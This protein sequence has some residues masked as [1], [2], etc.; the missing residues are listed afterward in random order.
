MKEKKVGLVTFRENDKILE[1]KNRPSDDV[2]NG[3][4][5]ILDE[6][7]EEEKYLL[8]KYGNVDVFYNFNDLS[9]ITLAY[10]LSVHKAQGSEYSYVYFIFDQSQSHMLYKKLI[11]TAISRARNK[12]VL[13]GN[14]EVFLRA[15]NKELI[16]RKTTLINRLN[17]N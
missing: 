3:D 10:A 13:I 8:V 14:K 1:L 16:N 17:N 11:Y 2:Y 12:L 15:V 6:I 9:D 7:D 5:G 4:V